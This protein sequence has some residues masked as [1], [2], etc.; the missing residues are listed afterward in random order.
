ML[1][2]EK[3]N[4]GKKKFQVANILSSSI[5]S[6][7]KSKSIQEF[8]LKEL[9][10]DPIEVQRKERQSLLV[11]KTDPNTNNTYL[12]ID[13]STRSK[14]IP[15]PVSLTVRTIFAGPSSCM[16]VER[17]KSNIEF[18]KLYPKES[19]S[20]RYKTN[21]EPLIVSVPKQTVIGFCV[22]SN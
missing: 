13:E 5:S 19:E 16:L 21:E 14:P 11:R 7:F 2:R 17:S 9:C 12:E 8:N 6:L 1:A 3:N 10:S 4:D 15:T 18:F 22:A 20:T